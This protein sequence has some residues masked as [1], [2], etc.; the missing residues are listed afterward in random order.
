VIGWLR[1]TPGSPVLLPELA[2][3]SGLVALGGDLWPERLLGAYRRGIFPWY[4]EGDPI[5]W[6]SPDPRAIF[7]LDGL[8]ISRRLR[9]TIRSGRFTL[10]VNRD[11]AGVIRGCADRPDDGTW[12]TADMIRAYEALHFLGHAHSVEAWHDGVLAGGLYGVAVGG[13]F[14]GESMF[15]RVRD[16]SKVA[17]AFLVD[18][19]RQRG[20]QLFDI[21][22]LTP[23][24]AR[25]GAVEIPRSDY[26]RRLSRALALAA[27]FD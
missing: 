2:D 4:D 1:R 21:Q 15:T 19:L 18:R 16:A 17:L 6:W 11:F 9:R 26:L 20:F 3:D 7:E 22:F 12:I 25:L 13:L 10:T 5:C 8:H 24:T 27:V 14:A 23:H